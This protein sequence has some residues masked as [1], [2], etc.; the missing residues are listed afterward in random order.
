MGV[1]AEP[2]ELLKAATGGG[3]VEMADAERC[4]GFGGSF[5]FLNYRLSGQ[6]AARK[7]RNAGATGAA[8]VAAGCPGCMMHIADALSQA[9]VKARAMHTLQVI[10]MALKT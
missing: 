3:L 7:A 5:S 2:R 10:A 8:L 9:H 1:H 4:C 6:I